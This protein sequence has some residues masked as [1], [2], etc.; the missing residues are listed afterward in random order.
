[1]KLDSRNRRWKSQMV[2]RSFP[3]LKLLKSRFLV[4]HESKMLN[5]LAN[6]STESKFLAN[7]EYEKLMIFLL[8]EMHEDIVLHD[9]CVYVVI[10]VL[11]F[12]LPL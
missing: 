2:E 4:Y 1:M 7:V 3:N 11:V 10:H 12:M 5:V 9:I 6:V 8:E